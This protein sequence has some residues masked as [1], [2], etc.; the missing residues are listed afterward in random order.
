M[1]RYKYPPD[2]IIFP[3]GYILFMPALGVFAWFKKGIA[4]NEVGVIGIFFWIFL[5]AMAAP[6]IEWIVNNISLRLDITDYG[7]RYKSLLKERQV[8]WND[9]IDIQRRIL[10]ERRGWHKDSAHK[11]DLL[12]KLQD[13]SKIKIFGILQRCDGKEGGIDEL[14]DILRTKTNVQQQNPEQEKTKESKYVNYLA[15]VGINALIVVL[16]FKFIWIRDG[17]IGLAAIYAV[18][19]IISVFIYIYRKKTIQVD[20]ILGGIFLIAAIAMQFKR[21]WYLLAELLMAVFVIFS[22]TYYYF[23]WKSLD[24]RAGQKEAE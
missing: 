7:F 16:Y 10:Y 11:N 15:S 14:E 13:G 21:N 20:A 2:K 9:I 19:L 4:L 17:I 6:I 1:D 24:N 18:A 22:V 3:Y 12:I 5:L 23:D 8:V